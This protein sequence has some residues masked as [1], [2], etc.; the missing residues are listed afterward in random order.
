MNGATSVNPIFNPPTTTTQID[1]TLQLTVTNEEETTI[2]LDWVTVTNDP[3]S[4]FF[5]PSLPTEGPQTV[6]E[7][8]KE[9]V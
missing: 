9:I 2:K 1:L 8:I 4:K 6:D 3:I 7:I 5:P